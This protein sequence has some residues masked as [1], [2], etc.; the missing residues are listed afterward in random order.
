M[1]KPRPIAALMIFAGLLS[2]TMMAG[3][4]KPEGRR[5][6]IVAKRYTFA[7]NKIT[8]KK[9]EAVTLVFKSTDVTHGFLMDAFNIKVEIRKGV[10][11][12]V[13]FSPSKAGTFEG[14]CSHFCG[15]GHG[16]MRFVVEVVE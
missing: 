10:P 9:G 2:T 1:R 6:D 15:V 8:V 4:A 7:P 5:I 12:E 14:G 13:T 11:T 16:S 3:D